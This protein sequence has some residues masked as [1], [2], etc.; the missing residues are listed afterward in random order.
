[1][2]P[3]DSSCWPC[4]SPSLARFISGPSGARRPWSLAGNHRRETETEAFGYISRLLSMIDE[5]VF[6][7]SFTMSW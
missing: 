4:G 6:G 2:T 1:M 3:R 5:L 7:Y